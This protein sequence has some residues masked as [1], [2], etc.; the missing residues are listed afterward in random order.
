M[1]SRWSAYFS[2]RHW[3]FVQRHARQL[4][5]DQR[6][7]LGALVFS[8]LALV[9]PWVRTDVMGY[10]LSY[11]T[12]F[13]EVTWLIGAVLALIS[14]FGLAVY[15]DQLFDWQRMKLPLS[16]YVLAQGLHAQGFILTLIAWSVLAGVNAN[17][18]TFI[19]RYG[20]FGTAIAHLVGGVA[21]FLAER[22]RQRLS[23]KAFFG[24]TPSA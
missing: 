11:Q 17:A 23:T 15:L 20:L 14:L 19:I 16:F 21:S 3:A 7:H 9:L 5:F 10:D 24:L 6:V 2:A 12:V 22:S 1:K 8:L 13:T 4:S 18:E